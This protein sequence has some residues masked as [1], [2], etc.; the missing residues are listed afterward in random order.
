MF[1][2]NVFD[3]TWEYLEPADSNHILQSVY[4]MDEAVIVNRRNVTRAEICT[5]KHL[6]IGIRPVPIAAHDLRTR[7][8]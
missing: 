4:D 7:K 1:V 8:C 3:L 2:E 6:S 5:K